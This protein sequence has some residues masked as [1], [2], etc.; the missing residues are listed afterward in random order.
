[1]ELSLV[2][3]KDHRAR[4]PSRPLCCDPVQVLSYR[5]GSVWARIATFFVR[6]EGGN[7]MIG[8]FLT[9]NKLNI[10]MFKSIHMSRC[11]GICDIIL[12]TTVLRFFVKLYLSTPPLE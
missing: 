7:D 4:S 12:S 8:T 11:V 5:N 1:M 10:H 3:P 6:M 9:I 2:P